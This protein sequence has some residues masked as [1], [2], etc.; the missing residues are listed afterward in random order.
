MSR[1]RSQPGTI[2]RL[3]PTDRDKLR[4]FAARYRFK[5]YYYYDGASP[6]RLTR[7]FHHQL[8]TKL[9]QENV[10]GYIVANQLQGVLVFEHLPWDSQ[11][12]GMPMARVALYLHEYDGS[13]ARR[14]AVQLLAKA[15]QVC[16]KRKIQ[17][18]MCRVN[19]RE[20]STAQ[21]LE[22]C[23]FRIADTITVLFVRL[24]GT[25]P[26]T[27]IT[28]GDI[29][30]RRM[31]S[32][33]LPSLMALSRTA[34]TNKKDILTRFTGDPVLAPRASALYAAWFKNS[35]QGEQGDIVWVAEVDHRPSGFIACRRA[36][37]DVTRHLGVR[38]GS[39]PLNAVAPKYRQQGIY[40]QLVI[41]ALKW[42]QRQGAEYVE[43]RTQI[44]TVG[45]HRAW[46]NLRGH[47]GSSDYIFH[48]WRGRR[49]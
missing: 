40:T 37:H 17:H 20:L 41:R 31:R 36:S 25:P 44:H 12:F 22:Q 24:Q 38:I 30:I 34:F 45:I 46:C 27:D 49:V 21:A 4:C 5:P 28:K 18:V 39:I 32:D 14:I 26:Y 6:K 47:L 3:T 48:Q 7:Y 1:L 43:I 11:L 29:H 19:T 15:D 8:Y 35:S 10:Y 16:V 13:Q 23:G 9:S 2:R 42:F 33:D